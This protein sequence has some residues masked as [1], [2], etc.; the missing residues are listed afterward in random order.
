MPKTFYHPRSVRTCPRPGGI[1][2][3]PQ[4]PQILEEERTEIG[5]LR[6]VHL[7][8]EG[9]RSLVP[10]GHVVRYAHRQ[11]CARRPSQRVRRRCLHRTTRE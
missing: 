8:L 7:H 2:R 9:C 5:E 4:V 6:F 1:D 10:Y 11:W 3:Y